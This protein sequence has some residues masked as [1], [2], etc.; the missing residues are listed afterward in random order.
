VYDITK[1]RVDLLSNGVWSGTGFP[2]NVLGASFG[3]LRLSEGTDRVLEA[4]VFF[5]HVAQVEES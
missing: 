5:A 4:S 3:P 1:R 2:D